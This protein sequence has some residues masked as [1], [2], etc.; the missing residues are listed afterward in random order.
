ML[1]LK[2]FVPLAILLVAA[3]VAVL[4][5]QGRAHAETRASMILEP[6]LRAATPE[7]S[8][9]RC[10]VTSSAPDSGATLAA[11]A[12]SRNCSAIAILFVWYLLDESYGI[13]WTK[14]AGPGGTAS[15]SCQDDGGPDDLHIDCAAREP[16]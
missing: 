12:E 7:P 8:V 1:R 11:N 4:V 10:L 16:S 3:V 6:T 5:P 13:C 14:C 2:R 9:E 15:F